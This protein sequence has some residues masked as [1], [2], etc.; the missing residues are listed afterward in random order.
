MTSKNNRQRGGSAMEFALLTLVWV[1]LLLGTAAM[2]AAMLRAS[3]SVQLARDAGHMYARGVDF[4]FPGNQQLLAQL[5]AGLGMRT[6]E[7]GGE[8]VRFG[9]GLEMATSGGDG[10]IILSTLTYVGRY[11]C[12]ALGLADNATPPNPSANCTNYGHFVFTHRIVIG[13]PALPASAMGD[14]DPALVDPVTGYIARDDY[15]KKAGARADRFTL[16]PKPREDG[17]DGF[18]AG[19]FAYLAETYFKTPDFPGFTS[20]GCTYTYAI[21]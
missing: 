21:F 9:G 8:P 13:N 11:Q 1:P 17:A 12:K 5:G 6:P 18:Q 20:G 14:P 4:A 16:L 10:K 15:V 19:Q 3:Q 2:G 7:G